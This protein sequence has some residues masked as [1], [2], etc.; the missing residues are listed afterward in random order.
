[1]LELLRCS[2][3]I[4][5]RAA[6]LSSPY[7][8]CHTGSAIA[9]SNMPRE[10]IHFVTGRFAEPMLRDVVAGL[11]A[12]I[13]FDYSVDVLPITVAALMTPEWIARHIQVPEETTR[14]LLP[15]YCSGDLQ[16]LQDIV[17]CPVE[18]GPKD[19][20]RLGQFFGH[21]TDL[22]DFG[23]WDIE[24]IAEIN[25]APRLTREQLVAEAMRLAA[26]GADVIDVGCDPGSRWLQVGDAVRTLIDRG[27]RVSID[28]FN[29]H[30][31]RDATSAGAELV[32]SVAQSNR[33]AAVDWGCE[34]VVVPNQPDQL[35]TMNE[36]AQWLIERGVRVRLDPILEPIG[37]GF[38]RSLLRYA[39]SRAQW[40]QA[41]MLMGIGNLTEL[42]DVDSAGINLLLAALCQEWSIKSVLT[43]QVINWART[44]VREF[45]VARRLA[46]YAQAH[47]S[48]PKHIDSRLIML[49]DPDVLSYNDQQLAELARQV[50][51]HNYRIFVA[52]GQLVILGGGQ[53]FRGSDAFQLFDELMQTQSPHVDPSHAFYLGFEL[54]KATIARQL[55]KEYRQDEAL[56]WGLLTEEES[57][58]HRL[59]KRKAKTPPGAPS[60][61]GE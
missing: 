8:Q 29:K 57:H 49:R 55:S 12:Q 11:A 16:A 30:E 46:R 24:I 17:A 33:E 58:R 28:S 44:S 3:A 48:P 23:A 53:I 35:E 7:F 38:G 61:E 37:V 52:D 26:D 47:Q 51:D 14:V 10:R 19:L 32:L 39:Q 40:P 15:G 36:T 45:D 34:V 27:L 31:V 22:A 54:C 25:Y 20:R 5:E 43:T 4:S 1:M 56:H 18:R 60:S 6:G 42:T 2:K 41:A 59:P 50:K 9:F 21:A 13:G